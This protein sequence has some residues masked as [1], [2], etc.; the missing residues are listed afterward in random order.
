[1]KNI[2]NMSI[3]TRCW[4][5]AVALSLTC[6]GAFAQQAGEGVQVPAKEHDAEVG[7]ISVSPYAVL[8][9][10]RYSSH[11]STGNVPNHSKKNLQF[12]AGIEGEYRFHANAGVS[13]GVIYSLE[14]ISV[15]KN[16]GGGKGLNSE[17]Y[18]QATQEYA[19]KRLHVPLLLCVHP[20]SDSRLCFKA[21]FQ[22]DFL[23]NGSSKGL[24]E[25]KTFGLTVPMGLS[26]RLGESILIDARYNAGLTKTGK[27]TFGSFSHSYF[28]LGL[29]LLLSHL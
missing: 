26:L 21:G 6:N 1:M 22:A 27:D 10:S 29:G 7:R 28:S 4:F 19:M 12:G 23:L 9:Y 13:L 5:L 17:Y 11:T 14:G 20:T 2:R 18:L 16:F 3:K 8:T 24:D 25:F 15:E